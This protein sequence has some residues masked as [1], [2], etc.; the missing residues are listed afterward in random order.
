M[1]RHG[2]ISDDFYKKG[3]VITQ[4]HAVRLPNVLRKE[5]LKQ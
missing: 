4:N 2:M 5:V 3:Q 1:A